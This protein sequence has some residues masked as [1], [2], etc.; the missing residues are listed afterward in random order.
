MPRLV[1]AI[2]LSFCATQIV[3][4]DSDLRQLSTADAGRGWESVGRLDVDR[5]GFCT[6]SLIEERLILTAAHCVFD[7]DGTRIAP[8]RFSFGA[9]LRNGRAEATRTVTRVTAHPDYVHRADQPLSLSVAVDIAVL[10]LDRPIRQ[11]RIAPF[12][13]ASQ[14]AKGARVGV[15]SYATGRANAPSLQEVCEVLTLQDGVVVLSCTADFGA[16]GAPVFWMNGNHPR[17]VSVISAKGSA[18]GQPVS[19]GTSLAAPLS[20]VLQAHAEGAVPQGLSRAGTGAKFVR[21]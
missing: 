7:D 13:L 6:A 3:A 17:I 11:G 8:E 19:L 18:L 10:E 12:T 9:G 21:P 2:L 1:L 5:G 16:S 4:Q 14:P 20:R 15:V